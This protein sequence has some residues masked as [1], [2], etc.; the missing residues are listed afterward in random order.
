MKVTIND[1]LKKK[2][3]GRKITMLTA[4]DYPF[5]Q[6]VDEADIDAILVGDSLAMVVQGL[7]NTLPVTMDEMIYH[8]KMVSRGVKNAMV[9]GDMPY[10][11]YHLSIDDAV[12]NAGRFIKEAGAHAVKIEG[13]REVAEKVE[14]MTK[15]EI[16]VMA[17]IG[18]TPQAIHRMG[19]YKVQGR[20]EEAAKRLVEDAKILQDAGAFSLI[21]EAI[22]AGLAAQITKDLSIPTIGIGAGPHCDGQVLVIHDVLGLFERFVP[23]FVKRYANLKDDALKAI[24]QYKEEVEKGLFPGKEHSF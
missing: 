22:P 12:R 16:P 3:E 21:L 15:A 9:I 11:S 19:G 13:S 4:Y 8:T 10:L 20:T 2:Q 18:L 5:A 1:F 24:K 7:E 14:A 6:I 17:H 23:K